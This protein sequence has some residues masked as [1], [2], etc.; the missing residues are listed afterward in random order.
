MLVTAEKDAQARSSVKIETRRSMRFILPGHASERLACARSEKSSKRPCRS[1]GKAAA[2][3]IA[4]LSVERPGVGKNTGYGRCA[5]RAAA[6]RPELQATPPEMINVRAPIFSAE[7]V[8]RRS[9]SSIT[10]RWK[11]DKRSSVGRGVNRSQ[12]SGD[13]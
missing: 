4:A 10:V 7:A 12:S 13:G 9:S 3:I 11:D 6:R 2:A 8:E 5:F 1:F